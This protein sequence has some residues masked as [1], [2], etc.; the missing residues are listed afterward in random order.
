MIRSLIS[1]GERKL[2]GVRLGDFNGF[3]E[4]HSVAGGVSNDGLAFIEH[5]PFGD[6]V[7][8]DVGPTSACSRCS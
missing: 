3:S 6:G 1:K 7:I 5:H 2:R 8:I 4:Y